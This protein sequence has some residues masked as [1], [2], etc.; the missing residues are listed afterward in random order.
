L[1]PLR[2]L[3][4]DMDDTL[5]LEE[6][7]VRSGFQFVAEWLQSQV[8]VP[9]SQTF[10]FMWS[11]H[12]RGDR[13]HIFDNL[14]AKYPEEAK[15]LKPI[16]LLA[17]YRNHTPVLAFHAGM[18]EFLNSALS[19]G[20]RLA[21]ISDGHLA[22]QTRKVEALGLAQLAHPILLTDAWGRAFWKPHARAFQTVEQALGCTGSDLAYLGDNPEKDFQAPNRLGWLTLRLRLSGQINN[23]AEP[24]TREA[25]PSL[26]FTSVPG[27]LE[28]LYSVPL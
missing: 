9:A 23:L 24:T 14:L 5:F 6:S 8:D 25:K 15:G 22:A 11:T 4:L 17:C 18:K 16:D 21:L 27:L 1:A 20:L 2:V 12:L 3:V 26:E 28:W 10:E 19:R 7:Y 13:G